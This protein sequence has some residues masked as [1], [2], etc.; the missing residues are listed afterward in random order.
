[1]KPRS[2]AVLGGDARQGYAAAALAA[3]GHR[4]TC[5]GV[6]PPEGTVVQTI[7]HAAALAGALAAAELVLCPVP[8]A[9]DGVHLTHLEG[10]EKIPLAVLG[11]LLRPGQFLL[12]GDLPDTLR[13]SCAARKIPAF[14]LL[15]RDD[16]ATRNALPTAE[17]VTALAMLRGAGNLARSECLVL[18]YGRCGS[19]IA[20]VLLR[21]RARVTV[22]LRSRA[23]ACA[24]LSAGCNAVALELL[25]AELPRF[26][27]VFNTIP[28]LVLDETALRLLQ[29]SVVLLDIANAPGGIDFGAAARLGL[30]AELLPG[31]PGKYAPRAAGEA[32][33]RTVETVLAEEAL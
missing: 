25:R 16:F 23:A 18:G 32:I 2:I 26:D 30:C 9:R 31:L 12:A 15:Q 28:A 6:P 8:C 17:A 4:V 21:L 24:A 29:N 13:A 10:G 11:D 5:F 14:A 27:F 22:A 1:M 3:A 33:A 20:D 19:A 7:Q